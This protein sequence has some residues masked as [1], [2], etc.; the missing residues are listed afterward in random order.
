MFERRFLGT[1]VPR[2]E[3]STDEI[4]FPYENSII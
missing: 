1:K 2:N 4:S 3:S